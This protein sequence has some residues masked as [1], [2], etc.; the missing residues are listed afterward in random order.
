MEENICKARD[1]FVQELRENHHEKL[2]LYAL[3]L[4]RGMNLKT[5]GVD[6]L[7]QEFYITVLVKWPMS[8]TAYRE[9]GVGYLLKILKFDSYDI[10]RKQKS[11]V[12][13]E[14]LFLTKFIGDA[15]STSSSFET[16]LSDLQSLMNSMLSPENVKIM[17]LYVKGFSYR[18]IKTIL[19]MPINTIAT[20]IARSKKKLKHVLEKLD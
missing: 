5:V 17:N 15:T 10:L 3:G 1:S 7:L 6:D 8:E 11:T 4:L 16:Q 9:K 2:L 20:K 19:N 12:R 18:E 14:E 13:L